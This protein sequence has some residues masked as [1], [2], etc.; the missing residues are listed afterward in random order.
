MRRVP[1]IE[2]QGGV[3][4][5]VRRRCL[6]WYLIELRGDSDVD[7][8]PGADPAGPGCIGAGGGDAGAAEEQERGGQVCVRAQ[9]ELQAH[10]DVH[11]G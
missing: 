11:S 10:Q 1:E 4:Q 7:S 5:E 6:L 2:L 3:L 9:P 8:D